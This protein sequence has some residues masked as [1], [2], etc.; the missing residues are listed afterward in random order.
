MYSLPLNGWRVAMVWP[1]GVPWAAASGCVATKLNGA[2]GAG[3]AGNKSVMASP[4]ATR[5]ERL[6]APLRASNRPAAAMNAN[7][8]GSGT[9]AT[10]PV[11]PDAVAPTPIIVEL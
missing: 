1:T 3:S 5:G 6:G 11:G 9:V 4:V 2:A 8:L 10:Q 7:A